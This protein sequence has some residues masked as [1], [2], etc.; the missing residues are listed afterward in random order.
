MFLLNKVEHK[1]RD[2]RPLGSSDSSNPPGV[3]RRPPQQREAEEQE[4]DTAVTAAPGLPVSCSR[5]PSRAVPLPVSRRTRRRRRR[6][7]HLARWRMCKDEAGAEGKA[8][9]LTR[10]GWRLRLGAKCQ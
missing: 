1:S 5:S 3:R 9:A 4:R 2:R 8:S 6:R 7:E 10:R